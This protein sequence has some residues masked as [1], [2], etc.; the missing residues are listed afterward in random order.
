MGI[1][2]IVSGLA[3]II[4]RWEKVKIYWPHLVLVILVFVIHI[5]EWWDAYSMRNYDYWRLPTFLFIILYP[6]NLYILSRILFPVNW[7][8]KEIDLKTFYFANFRRVFM[9]MISLDLLA[10]IYN[11]FISGYAVHEQVVQ[12]LVMGV[13]IFTALKNSSHEMLHKGIVLVLLLISVVT[14]IATWNILLIPGH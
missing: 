3:S 12:F 9:L 8:G 2:Q 11:I 1:T 6:V 14:L 10:I 4:H 5:Q 7:R 13:L